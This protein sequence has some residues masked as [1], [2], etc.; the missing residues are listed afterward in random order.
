MH[1]F[2]LRYFQSEHFADELGLKLS[3]T[4]SEPTRN[5]NLKLKNIAQF[6]GPYY[7]INDCFGP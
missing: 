2:I 1:G 7:L 4:L 3:H 5:H 6:S